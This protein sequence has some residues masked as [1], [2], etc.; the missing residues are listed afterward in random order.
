VISAQRGVEFV[1]ERLMEA[2]A[3]H[4]AR[5][6]LGVRIPRAPLRPSG[7]FGLGALSCPPP[8]RRSTIRDSLTLVQD[9]V[10]ASAPYSP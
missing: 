1:T 6:G 4:R 9:L 10:C 7:H 3:Q 2:A 8:P 5:K